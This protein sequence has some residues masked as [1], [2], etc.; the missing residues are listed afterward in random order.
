LAN[1]LSRFQF[2][3]VLPSTLPAT[4]MTLFDIFTH[5]IHATLPSHLPNYC[6]SCLDSAIMPTT[7]AKIRPVFP[8]T[9]TSSSTDSVSSSR[10]FSKDGLS[11]K[12]G[13]LRSLSSPAIVHPIVPSVATV[14]MTARSE[15]REV[16]VVT[17]LERRDQ[18]VTLKWGLNQNVAG[19][20]RL[21]IDT[22]S[23]LVCH[24]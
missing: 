23:G 19:L 2:I 4:R 22:Q 1:R 18:V 14:A 13:R 12:G 6:P 11:N 8:R 3:F 20:G 17:S 5:T 24:S 16:Q 15:N 21:D 7:I 9:E 10:S